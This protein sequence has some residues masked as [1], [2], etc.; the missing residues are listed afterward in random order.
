MISENPYRLAHDIRGIGSKTA[1]QIAAKLAS[2]IARSG[3]VE[4]W[5]ID[6]TGISKKGRHSVEVARQ[7]CGQ[8]GEQDNCQIAVSLSLTRLRTY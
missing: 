7:Y 2:A 6:D 8:L 5:I 4:A 1:D 3:P